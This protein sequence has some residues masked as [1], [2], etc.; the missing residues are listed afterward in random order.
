MRTCYVDE[1]GFT[2]EDLLAEDQPIFVQ[3]TNDFCSDEAHQLIGT[4]FSGLGSAELKYSRLARGGRHH[5]KIVEL[6]RILAG[7]PLR[8][9]AWIAH[10]E[11]ALMT[12]IVD[13][14][15]IAVPHSLQ[16]L[17]FERNAFGIVRLENHRSAA[18]GSAKA[19]MWSGWP[20]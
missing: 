9:G 18:S 3:A 20:T 10:K 17:I 5:D 2:G 7:D 4:T 11:Y 19:L 1:T 12:L 15:R 16:N 6:V 13:W 8:V 14:W